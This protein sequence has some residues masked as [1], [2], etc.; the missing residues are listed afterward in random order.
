MKTGHLYRNLNVSPH[1]TSQLLHCSFRFSS[2]LDTGGTRYVVNFQETYNIRVENKAT[3]V[4]FF[5][6]FVLT[7]HIIAIART[8]NSMSVKT[9]TEPLYRYI[10]LAL[11][12]SWALPACHGRGRA[13]WNV[14]ARIPDAEDIII[15]QRTHEAQKPARPYPFTCFIK[16]HSET[17]VQAVAARARIDDAYWS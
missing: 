3:T 12:H 9:L 5:W 11:V 13:H 8:H 6:V 14:A 15:V 16:R 1:R 17:F 4:A 2:A 10:I 7:S